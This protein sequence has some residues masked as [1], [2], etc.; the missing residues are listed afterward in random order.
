MQESHGET[1]MLSDKELNRAFRFG[2]YTFISGIFFCIAAVIPNHILWN[3]GLGC[4]VLGFSVCVS[5]FFIF[6]LQ[7]NP[8]D[9]VYRKEDEWEETREALRA[10]KQNVV[11]SCCNCKYFHGL[12]YIHCAAHPYKEDF[13]ACED[14]EN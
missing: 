4:G 13:K 14:Y 5:A 7:M 1:K 9:Y 11:S 8:K 2:K 10:H 3:W 12:D 6:L